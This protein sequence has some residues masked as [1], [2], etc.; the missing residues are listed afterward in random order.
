MYPTVHLLYG[1]VFKHSRD[2]TI[3]VLC[4]T[5]ACFVDL[6]WSLKISIKKLLYTVPLKRNVALAHASQVTRNWAV[7]N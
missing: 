1:M 6:L 3:L 2:I 5:P 4:T 7:A